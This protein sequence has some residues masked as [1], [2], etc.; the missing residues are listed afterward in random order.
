M[1]RWH[2]DVASVWRSCIA[3]ALPDGGRA[4]LL[5]WGDPSLFDSTLRIA[6]RLASDFDL[7]VAVVPGVTALQALTAAHRS[8]STRSGSRA[9]RRRAESSRSADGRGTPTPSPSSWTA[10]ARSALSKA[11]S[12]SG[13]EPIS[14]GGGDPSFMA[15]SKPSARKSSRNAPKRADVTVGSWTFISSDGSVDHDAL[16]P[17]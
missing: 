13:G 14:N 6:E 16:S 12:R 1:N 2:D 5:V 15:R 17:T 4:A 11:R 8:R 10:H 3:E 9:P 7:T